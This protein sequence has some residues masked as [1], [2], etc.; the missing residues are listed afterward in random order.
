MSSNFEV[1][2]VEAG[3]VRIRTDSPGERATSTELDA[4]DA[5]MQIATAAGLDV[6][7]SGVS[8]STEP[9]ESA[10]AEPLGPVMADEPPV[11]TQ[12]PADATV[13]QGADPDAD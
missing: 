4:I 8:Q 9:D 12:L 11:A 2:L 5:I 3:R 1:E 6:T 13:E 7:V 10:P